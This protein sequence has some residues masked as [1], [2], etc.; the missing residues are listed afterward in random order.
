[1]IEAAREALQQ[2]LV[3]LYHEGDLTAEQCSGGLK[4]PRTAAQV[5]GYVGKIVSP[6]RREAQA[7]S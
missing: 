3:R 7:A 2:R 6:F 5:R 4:L 1:L